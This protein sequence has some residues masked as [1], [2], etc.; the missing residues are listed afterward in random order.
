VQGE[1]ELGN[2]SGKGESQD[3]DADADAETTHV[4]YIC[5]VSGV[6]TTSQSQSTQ[7]IAT[8]MNTRHA[9]TGGCG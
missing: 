2:V 6:Q 3:A 1:V 4:R 9:H 5:D 7:C 8:D